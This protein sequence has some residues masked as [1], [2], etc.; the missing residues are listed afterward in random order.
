MS[1][2]LRIGGAE[3]D[4]DDLLRECRLDAYRI[5]RKG[6]IGLLKSRG[7]HEKSSVHVDVSSAGFDDL[8][9]QVADAVTFLRANQSAVRAAVTFPGVEWAQL[10][11]GVEHADVAIDSK[12]L[13]P[14][15]LA[16]AGGM[17]LAIELSIYPGAEPSA[18]DAG[19][20]AGPDDR[21]P[22]AP[23]RR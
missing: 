15:L 5:D 4:A 21:S 20:G 12:Y 22:A 1:C 10:D 8:P 3:L 18:D 6:E 9:G 23:T 11:F 7:P 19:Q 2:I 16:L 17:G 13:K 14:E